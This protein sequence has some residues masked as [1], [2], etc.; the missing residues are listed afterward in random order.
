MDYLNYSNQL[1]KQ[2]KANTDTNEQGDIGGKSY[3]FG[4]LTNIG[5]PTS[6]SLQQDEL[7]QLFPT[8]VLISKYPANYDKE[9]DWI[10][11]QKLD[12]NEDLIN[13]GMGIR[14]NRQSEDRYL[15]L[16]HI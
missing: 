13:E 11:K 5:D 2:I 6:N 1:T 14:Y 8:P 12:T 3:S 9:L 16:I 4:D 15:S 7:L 10:R